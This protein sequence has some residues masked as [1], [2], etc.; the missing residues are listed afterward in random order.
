MPQPRKPLALHRLQ[1]TLNVTRHRGRREIEA[2]GDL[3]AEAPPGGLSEAQ[4][5]VWAE[6]CAAAPE[7][8][9]KSADRFLLESFVIA[10]TVLREANAMR[11][12]SSLLIRS[13]D[14]VQISPLAGEIRRQSRLI[15]ELGARLGFEPQARLRLMDGG[16]AD[17]GGFD[18]EFVNRFGPLE[19]IRGGRE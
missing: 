5:A 1:G 3:T 13:R 2:V 18:P 17:D 6:V 12:A 8:L 9:L 7:R 19:L 16:A 4:K 10:I 11:V 14:G 15:A